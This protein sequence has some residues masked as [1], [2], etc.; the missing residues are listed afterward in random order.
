MSDAG[1]DIPGPVDWTCA[2]HWIEYNKVNFTVETWCKTGPNYKYRLKVKVRSMVESEI[3]GVKLEG[4]SRE[5][6]LRA[7]GV[8]ETL[9][10]PSSLKNHIPI[11]K[12]ILLYFKKE[13]YFG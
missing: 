5:A 12:R 11:I 2:S 3:I 6:V 13:N 8:V 9:R 10:S 7:Y 1:I 4:H